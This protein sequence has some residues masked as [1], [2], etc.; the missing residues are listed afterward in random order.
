[1]ANNSKKMYIL[2]KNTNDIIESVGTSGSTSPTYDGC[3]GGSDTKNSGQ[4]SESGDD[5]C[6]ELV[7]RS[8]PSLVAAYG[9]LILFVFTR[10]TLKRNLM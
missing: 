2:A 6:K 9:C 7:T 5:F 10:T 3:S 8:S 1:M 4:E